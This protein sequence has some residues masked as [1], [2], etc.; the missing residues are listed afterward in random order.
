M[1]ADVI[2]FRI[3]FTKKNIEGYIPNKQGS[4]NVKQPDEI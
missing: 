4:E 1:P 2:P 3:L